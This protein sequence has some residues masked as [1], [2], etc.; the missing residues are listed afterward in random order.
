VRR[1][2]ATESPSWQL[3]SAGSLFRISANMVVDEALVEG[4][5]DE[6][7]FMAI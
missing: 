6:Q 7:A 3:K 1:P 4:V 2:I 5:L